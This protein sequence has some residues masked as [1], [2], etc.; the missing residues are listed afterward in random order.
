MLIF[1]YLRK[2][3]QTLY[4]KLSVYRYTYLAKF[5]L[6]SRKSYGKI[7]EN[8]L[9]FYNGGPMPKIKDTIDSDS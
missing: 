1:K 5:I 2:F 4:N 6:F 3:S 7:L 9:K 8:I